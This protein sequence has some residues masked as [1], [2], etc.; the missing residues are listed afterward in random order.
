MGLLIKGTL[1]GSVAA[2]VMVTVGSYSP[3]ILNIIGFPILIMSLLTIAYGLV[4]Y[5][6]ISNLEL[7]PHQIILGESDISFSYKGKMAFKI[8]RGKI[9]SLE[10]VD[11]KRGY[12]IAF[13]A[14]DIEIVDPKFSLER[15]KAHNQKQFG[16]ALIFPYFTRKSFQTCMNDIM[17]CDKSL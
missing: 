6:K 14:R 13:S 16:K 3:S 17:H 2:L 15:F 4:P 7:N 5:R 9:N 10:Y 8:P 11:K 1:I 12:G